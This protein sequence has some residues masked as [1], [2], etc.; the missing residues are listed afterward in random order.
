MQWWHQE[1]NNTWKVN[2]PPRSVQLHCQHQ[3]TKL[4]KTENIYLLSVNGI[5]VR[6]Y[7]FF[8]FWCIFPLSSIPESGCSQQK[9]S[10][11]CISWL[12]TSDVRMQ[13]LGHR[14]G[15]LPFCPAKSRRSYSK[16]L[17]LAD[18]IIKLPWGYSSET[19]CSS[20]RVRGWA[21]R[22]SLSL[23]WGFTYVGPPEYP[24]QHA[25]TQC[26]TPFHLYMFLFFSILVKLGKSVDNC[27]IYLW[28]TC[29][30]WAQLSLC[31]FM[32]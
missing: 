29:I 9:G 22:Q 7:G 20:V 3:T 32:S 31:H 2:A 17:C 4:I 10:T 15:V 6:V 27:G 16:L 8:F 11:Q 13:K 5:R 12:N 23:W 24:T 28:A 26:V 18:S 30:T 14:L 25:D 21:Q 1:E 19:D